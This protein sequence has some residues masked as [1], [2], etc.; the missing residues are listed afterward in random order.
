M[1]A[2]DLLGRLLGNSRAREAGRRLAFSDEPAA[3]Y[4]IGDVHGRLDLLQQLEAQIVADAADLAGEVWLLLLGDVIDRGPQS[5]QVVEHLLAP[6]PAGFRR[7]C[8]M[9]NHEDML[10]DFLAQPDPFAP[11]LDNGGIATLRSYGVPDEAWHSR[12]LEEIVATFLPQAH[13]DFFEQL[14]VVIETPH[15]FF[16]HAGI[17]PGRPLTA[18]A[19]DDLLWYRDDYAADY[20][21]LP[22][23]VVHGHTPLP[24][25]MVR[26]RR[27]A[28]DTGACFSGMLSAARLVAGAAPVLIT[29]AARPGHG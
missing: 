29:T 15:F 11:W 3:I 16:A 5:A 28:L 24:A 23:T 2:R 6:P 13:V 4:A 8:L 10:L 20:G 26:P 9:G 14:P 12:P 21:S 18:Q 17:R 19:R 1:A 25:P 22:K 7:F 27:V